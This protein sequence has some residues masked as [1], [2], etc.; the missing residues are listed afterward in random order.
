MKSQPWDH[1]FKSPFCL[2]DNQYYQP[3][4]EKKLKNYPV[5]PAEILVEIEDPTNISTAERGQI[6]SAIER[7][8]MAL[9]RFKHTD[10]E[11]RDMI[12]AF[13][14]SL[15]LAKLDKHLCTDGH[16]VTALQCETETQRKLYI[17]YTDRAINWHTDGYYNQP[18]DQI[19]GMVLHCVR[20]SESGGSNF[21]LD[22]EM[23]YLRL[24]DENPDWI[25]ALMQKDAMTIPP[26]ENATEELN[27]Y[28]PGA[29][30]A[31][32]RET[33]DLHMRFTARKRNV[34]WKDDPLIT[35]AL[36]R[37]HELLAHEESI[38]R[39]TMEPGMGLI[40]NNIP[41]GREAFNDSEEQH[42]LMYRVRSFDRVDV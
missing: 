2:I 42:R 21:L 35:A 9:Y 25:A 3:W 6:K 20:S 13:S 17:P 39:L 32:N 14:A 7:C 29:V 5:D 30:F 36:E 24:R 15:G 1:I 19:Q 22:H 12:R 23:I 27:Q 11:D 16:G 40:C 41:H 8:N 33:A 4:R 38:L 28:R 10:G 18:E 34:I 26:N 31:V 37:I